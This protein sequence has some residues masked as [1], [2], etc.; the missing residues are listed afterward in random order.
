M[1]DNTLDGVSEAAAAQIELIDK[2]LPAYLIHAGMAGAYIGLAI[3]LIFAL[4]TPMVGTP[5]EPLR[6]VVMAGAFGIALSLVIVAGSELF[7]GNAMIMGVGALEGRTSWGALGKVWVWSWIGNLFGS[8]LVAAMAAWGG[9]FSDPTLVYAVAE[10]K[11]TLSPLELFIQGIFCN[12]LVVLAVWSNF[13]LENAIAKLVMIWWCLLAFIGTGFEHSVANM[14]VLS[15][16]NF[17]TITTGQAG[18][19]AIN[20]VNMAYNISIV[21]VGN[22]FA[23]VVMMGAAYWYINES[24]K[25]DLSADDSFGDEGNIASADD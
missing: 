7:T 23:G 15:L 16:A 2:K 9:V 3:L 22:T 20:W 5:L 6:G 21:T 11:M 17:L 19:A 8:L 1:Y 25:I 18:P 13:R 12:W 10:T 24:Y 4:G 14:T